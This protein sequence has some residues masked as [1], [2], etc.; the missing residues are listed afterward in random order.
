MATLQVDDLYNGYMS[1]L[2][3]VNHC[4]LLYSTPPKQGVAGNSAFSLLAQG[5]HCIFPGLWSQQHANGDMCF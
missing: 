4:T 5:P 3:V 1:L 2:V